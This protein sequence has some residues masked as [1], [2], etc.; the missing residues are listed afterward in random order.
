MND[1][2]NEVAATFGKEFKRIRYASEVTMGVVASAVNGDEVDVCRVETGHLNPWQG[3]TLQAALKAIQASQDEADVLRRLA[4]SAPNAPLTDME[5]LEALRYHLYSVAELAGGGVDAAVGRYAIDHLG[6]IEVEGARVIVVR[7]GEC[8]AVSCRRGWIRQR[9]PTARGRRW[10]VQPCPV[11]NNQEGRHRGWVV[12]K[13][14]QGGPLRARVLGTGGRLLYVGEGDFAYVPEL[15]YGVACTECSANG[16]TNRVPARHGVVDP[17]LCETCDG[18]G[19][20]YT[21]RDIAALSYET[22]RTRRPAS[23]E[24]DDN[25][26]DR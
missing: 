13:D 11:C 22:R 3:E 26:I 20:L 17:V 6:D 24:P 9:D 15:A 18:A 4:L 5:R 7:P 2:I 8:P 21:K 25:R 1:P 16:V 14:P 19:R 12:E 10:T 23:A